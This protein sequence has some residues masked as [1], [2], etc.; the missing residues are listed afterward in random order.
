MELSSGEYAEEKFAELLSGACAAQSAKSQ[1]HQ[2]L[3]KPQG[4]P[5]SQGTVT[6]EGD[7]R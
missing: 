3:D 2:G 4:L 7:A 6:S 1:A 5:T